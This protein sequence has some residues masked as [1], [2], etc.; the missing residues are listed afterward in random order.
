MKT[1]E[2]ISFRPEDR[3]ISIISRV[4]L[5]YTRGL[6]RLESDIERNTVSHV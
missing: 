3:D 1:R 4:E 5:I 2:G 6:S